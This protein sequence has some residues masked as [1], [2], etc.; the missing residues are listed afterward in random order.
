MIKSFIVDS[1]CNEMR[2]DRYL[3]NKYLNLCDASQSHIKLRTLFYLILKFKI[4]NG[5]PKLRML[6]SLERFNIKWT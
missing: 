2:L 5:K 4:Y 1:T 6:Q 3:R